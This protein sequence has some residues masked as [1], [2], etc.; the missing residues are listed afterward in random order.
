MELSLVN[1][2]EVG[3][4]VIILQMRKW[5]LGEVKWLPGSLSSGRQREGEVKVSLL[6]S[7]SYI[8]WM[9]S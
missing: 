5:R 2:L 4:M 8:F 1:T 7:I 9:F 3:I 6:R